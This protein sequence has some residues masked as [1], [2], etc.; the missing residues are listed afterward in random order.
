[1]GLDP[2]K[3]TGLVLFGGYG[4]HS[5][6]EIARR[7]AAAET[8]VQLIF[9]CGRNRQLH[10]RLRS[11]DLPFPAHIQGFTDNA[12]CGSVISSLASRDRAR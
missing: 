1:M 3:P 5:M 6:V 10:K 2:E 8:P 11:M 9:L 4:S 12:T 7:M